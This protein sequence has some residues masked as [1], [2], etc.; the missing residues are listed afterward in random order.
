MTV[1]DAIVLAA[2]SSRRF[3]SDKRLYP[4]DGL[5]MLQRAV[6]A[7]VEVVRT[8]HVILKD[9]DR[10]RM[11]A[12]L[13]PFARDARIRPVLLPD[14]GRGMGSNLARA[15]ALLPDDGDAAL[16]MLADLPWLHA[17]TVQAVVA[18]CRPGSIVVPVTGSGRQ[19]HPVLFARDFF[20]ALQH[21]SGDNGARKVLQ[22]HSA[23]V[24]Q[25]RVEDDG[26]WRDVD[27]APV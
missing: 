9:E 27:S 21:L 5:P 23:A 6:A 14:P 26:I 12:L 15:V 20:P 22:Q 17:S 16:V 3:G 1:V 8:V 4:V 19:G 18:A 7:V 10:D 13:G 24:K 25:L 2:G 11:A